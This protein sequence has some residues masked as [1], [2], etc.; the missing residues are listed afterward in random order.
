MNSSIIENSCTISASSNLKKLHIHD[1]D[2]VVE[3]LSESQSLLRA[4]IKSIRVWAQILTNPQS[5]EVLNNIVNK[6]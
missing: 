4:S 1:Q 2:L 3:L 5:I 6:T